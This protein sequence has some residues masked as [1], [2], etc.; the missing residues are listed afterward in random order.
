MRDPVGS[1]RAVTV[2][3]SDLDRAEA[4]WGPLLGLRARSRSTDYVWLGEFSPGVQL[5]LQHVPEAKTGKNRVHLDLHSPDPRAL[6]SRVEALG[7]IQVK[8]VEEDDYSLTVLA[9]P[10]G[11]EFCV[12][13]RLS[14]GL[15]DETEMP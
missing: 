4:F 2:D 14:A 11:N 6:V 10:D 13:A 8:D 15:T 3:V 7:A 1:V 9:D 5:V 12:L